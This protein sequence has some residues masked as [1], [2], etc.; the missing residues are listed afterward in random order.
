LDADGAAGPKE[1]DPDA[2]EGSFQKTVEERFNM[3]GAGTCCASLEEVESKFDPNVGNGVAN[4]CSI[5]NVLWGGDEK[6]PS[7]CD[8]AG[9][10]LIGVGCPA[11]TP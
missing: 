1:S 8:R 7:K 5:L 6:D 3:D 4:R 10:P 11:A 2:V 9:L